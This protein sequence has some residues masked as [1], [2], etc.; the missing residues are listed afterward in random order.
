MGGRD[1]L[2]R[3]DPQPLIGAA[4]AAGDG[5]AADRAFEHQLGSPGG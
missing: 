4:L 5:L 2:L 3:A 1:V